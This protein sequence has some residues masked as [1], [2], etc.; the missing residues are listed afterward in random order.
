MKRPR[1]I[2]PAAVMKVKEEK[3]DFQLSRLNQPWTLKQKTFCDGR[4]EIEVTVG[5]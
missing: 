1:A 2:N 4:C 3:A 5:E